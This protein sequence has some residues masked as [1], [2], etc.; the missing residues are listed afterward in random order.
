MIMNATRRELG[1]AALC[2]ASIATCLKKREREREKKGKREEKKK[3]SWPALCLVGAPKRGER[4]E[5]ERE[6]VE[7]DNSAC[8]SGA[9]VKVGPEVAVRTEGGQR[10]RF[11]CGVGVGWGGPWMD[12][13]MDRWMNGL[14]VVVLLL[15][16]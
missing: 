7:N 15:L 13:W 5:R 6:R 12:G 10:R 2:F 9:C 16:F 1:R 14:V 4:G 8:A 3:K 11:G